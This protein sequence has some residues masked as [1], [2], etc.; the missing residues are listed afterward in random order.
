MVDGGGGSG[1]DRPPRLNL[2]FSSYTERIL[3]TNIQVKIKESCFVFDITH[4]H[5]E[6]FNRSDKKGEGVFSRPYLNHWWYTICYKT[7]IDQYDNIG[8]FGNI[9]PVYQTTAD[10]TTAT[11]QKMNTSIASVIFSRK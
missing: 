3:L 1:N 9:S 7:S 11:R 4:P 6:N 5:W 8:N 2:F 10:F